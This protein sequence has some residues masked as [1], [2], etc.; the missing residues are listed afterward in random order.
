MI[1]TVRMQ[2]GKTLPNF[3]L[4]G[5]I[6]T[7]LLLFSEVLHELMDPLG[8]SFLSNITTHIHIMAS[9][10]RTRWSQT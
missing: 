3:C 10:L 2:A 9:F 5:A 8:A 7:W 1:S 6:N 4:R